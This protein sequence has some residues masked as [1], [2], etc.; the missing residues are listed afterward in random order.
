MN[1]GLRPGVRD[2]WLR[3]FE[4]LLRLKPGRYPLC[5]GQGI[6]AEDAVTEL[7]VEIGLDRH[8]RKQLLSGTHNY[9]HLHRRSRFCSTAFQGSGLRKRPPVGLVPVYARLLRF[10]LSSLV[11]R[12]PLEPSP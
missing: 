10:H 8:E 3:R 6:R 4:A 5:D 12:G 2:H 1:L 11:T 7:V 9:T